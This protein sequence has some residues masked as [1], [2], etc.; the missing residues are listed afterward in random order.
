MGTSPD[1][2]QDLLVGG[3]GR[4]LRLSPG[5]LIG[6]YLHGSLGALHRAPKADAFTLEPR[7]QM[8]MNVGGGLEVTLRKRITVRFDFREWIFFDEN[9]AQSAEEYTGGL[10]IF[11]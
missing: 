8:A 1:A 2:Q 4:T 9:Q 7:S 3:L 10:A 5:A 11:F 6:P